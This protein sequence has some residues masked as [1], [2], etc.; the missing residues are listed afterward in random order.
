MAEITFYNDT[1][2]QYSDRE[3]ANTLW[4]EHAVIDV[5][6]RLFETAEDGLYAGEST[7]KMISKLSRFMKST[8]NDERFK[9][10]SYHFE[11]YIDNVLSITF[12]NHDDIKMSIYFDEADADEEI[13]DVEE[14][15]L[16]SR[17]RGHLAMFSG[18][19]EDVLVEL[20][21]IL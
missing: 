15:V 4:Q 2:R 12:P 18:T 6:N 9:H 19:I 13:D 5:V 10:L 20:N 14:A 7:S 8:S 17:V 1:Y 3:K 11:Q 21:E 16:M